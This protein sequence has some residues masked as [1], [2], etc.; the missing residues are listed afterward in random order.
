[1]TDPQPGMFG[2]WREAAGVLLPPALFVLGA[3]GVGLLVGW[4]LP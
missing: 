2:S 4:L 1:M 3:A